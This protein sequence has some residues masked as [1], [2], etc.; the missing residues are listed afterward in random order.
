MTLSET[1]GKKLGE[2]YALLF[3]LMFR[4]LTSFT[5]QFKR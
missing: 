4:F 3:L 1:E 5:L 2:H